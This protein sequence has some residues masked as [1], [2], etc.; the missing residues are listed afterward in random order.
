MAVRAPCELR[1]HQQ[2][3]ELEGRSP[4]DGTDERLS[5]LQ[6]LLRDDQARNPPHPAE[7]IDV[8]A[9]PDAPQMVKVPIKCEHVWKVGTF[10]NLPR[11][12]V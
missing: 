9:L 7:V 1:V 4:T 2:A 10:L 3:R 6:W 8:D 12:R 5:L 11:Y